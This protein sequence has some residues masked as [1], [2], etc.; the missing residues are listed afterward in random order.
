MEAARETGVT[1]EV[2]LLALFGVALVWSATGPADGFTWTLE[3]LPAVLGAAVLLVT[4]RRFRFSRLTYTW[5]FIHALVL[6]VGG[7]YTYAEVPLFNALRDLLEL[8]RNH[9]DRLGHFVQGFVPALIARE[10]LLRRSPVGP[11]R[12]LYFFVCCICL[13][14]SALY[15][16]IEALVSLGVWLTTGGTADAF[17][18]TQGDVW[19]TQWDMA[20]ALT[21]AILAQLFLS[22][23]Q[24]RSLARVSCG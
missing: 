6:L 22:R 10:V 9:Y 24:D 2:S 7:R 8:E 13:S 3:V 4:F 15:E 23:A 21:G 16:L 19:D 14:I 11:G 20:M 18:G 17:L 12:W 1:Y 5:I